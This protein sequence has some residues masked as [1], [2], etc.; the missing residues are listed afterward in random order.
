M[1]LWWNGRHAGLRAQC[2]KGRAGS[3]P[4]KGTNGLIICNGSK[5]GFEPTGLGSS[6][7][8]TSNGLV[9]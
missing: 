6:P 9:T 5:V 4:V 1:P 7:S 8:E 3:S 2:S